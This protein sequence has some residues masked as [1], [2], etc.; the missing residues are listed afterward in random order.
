MAERQNE[1]FDEGSEDVDMNCTSTPAEL[2][3]GTKRP[4][5]RNPSPEPPPKSPR[6]SCSDLVVPPLEAEQPDD[7]K[8]ISA[9]V[10]EKKETMAAEVTAPDVSPRSRRKSWRRSTRGRRS[11]PALPNTSQ[12]LCKSI[13][14]DLSDD[15]RLEKLMEAAMQFTVKRLQNT[16]LTLPGA[17]M[18]SFQ[19]QVNSLQKEWNILAK[20]ISEEN[21][22]SSSGTS[23]D[24][25]VQRSVERTK[26]ALSRLQA[27]SSSWE[28]LL[29]KHRCRA[30]E[31]AK[32]VEL[33]KEKGVTLNPSVEQSSQSKLILSK[34]DYQAV[35]HRQQRVLRNMELVL[36]SQCMMMRGLL[37]FQEHSQSLVKETSSR[38][39]ETA[40]LQDLPP[41][42]VRQLLNG[43]KS[44][45]SS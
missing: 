34:P 20:T 4:L 43:P 25:A 17:D 12:S 29:Q 6:T 15:E 16:L 1:K 28:A 42:P 9:E 44:A 21:L 3:Q 13:S 41:S 45:T 31:L 36:D 2:S 33:G 10:E 32:Q 35:L 19:T 27:E 26:E 8:P 23:S 5:D 18:E 24:P 30:E 39:A 22:V 11:L 38:L 40:G 7:Q 14:S 37:S